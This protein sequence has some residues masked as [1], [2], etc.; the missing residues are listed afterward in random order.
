M[1][2]CQVIGHGSISKKK[3]SAAYVY[4]INNLEGL[5]HLTNLINGKMRGSK[6]FQLNKL[7]DYLKNKSPGLN[8]TIKPQ[9]S[10]SLGQNN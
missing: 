1:L 5:I 2:L 7:I 9:D 4:T 3:Q 8:M 6:F 10:S